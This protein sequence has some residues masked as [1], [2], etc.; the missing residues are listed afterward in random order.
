MKRLAVLSD[1][2]GNLPALEAVLADAGRHGV[3]LAPGSI[4][5]AGDSTGGS[6]SRQAVERLRALGAWAIRGNNED[7]L[8]SYHR[9]QAPADWYSSSRWGPIRF[10]Y[11]QFDAAGLDYLAALPQQRVVALDGA[12]PLR[13]VHGSPRNPIE[14]LIPDGDT[15]LEEQ[16][17]RAGIR[18]RDPQPL[19]R[20]VAGVD[21]PLL[22]CGHSHIAWQQQAGGCHVLNPG[23]AGAP[24]NGD[25]RAQYALLTWHGG[26]WQVELRAVAY[27]R[28]SMWAQARDSGFLT[29][30]GAFARA[31]LLGNQTGLNVAGFLVD[32][33][34]GLA[35]AAGHTWDD[36]PEEIWE[37]AAATFDWAAF[38]R[39]G[40][41]TP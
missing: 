22:V 13:V 40:G 14:H 30:G 5:V 28:A 16:F 24:I 25:W 29:S 15:A 19:A 34:M 26:R 2:H 4:V 37:R 41:E 17:R 35:A 36:M 23:S 6:H 7:Y 18:R 20:L 33:S 32:H 1:V 11:R 12:L 31:C 9:G 10:V 27:D 8:L 21:E 38:A 3:E 39:M